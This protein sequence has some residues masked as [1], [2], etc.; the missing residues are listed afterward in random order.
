MYAT[1]ILEPSGQELVCRAIGIPAGTPLVFR[2]LRHSTLV[3][4]SES[5]TE[6]TYR[7]S[8]TDL[9]ARG[10]GDF[11]VDVQ[12]GGVDSVITTEWQYIASDKVRAE[13]DAWLSDD[14][15]HESVE[16]PWVSAT[17]HP[18]E[19]VAYLRIHD[20]DVARPPQFAGSVS[21]LKEATRSSIYELHPQETTEHAFIV[22]CGPD[23]MRKGR[24]YV[25]TSAEPVELA[26]S[27]GWAFGSG[28]AFHGSKLRRASEVAHALRPVRYPELGKAQYSSIHS[29]DFVVALWRPDG[30]VEF[31]TDYF[32]TAAWY[33]YRSDRVSIVASSLLLAATLALAC[34]E[35]LAL[36]VETVDADFTSLT[37]AFQQPLLDDME[38]AG[39]TCVRPDTVL[40]ADG[41][42]GVSRETSQLGLDLARPNDSQSSGTRSCSMM[43]S[44][45]SL[46]TA[47]QSRT[48]R[49]SVPSDATLRVVWTRALCSPHF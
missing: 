33:E 35:R 27:G 46:Q 28:C 43:R 22:T 32:G 9:A 40:V 4:E 2:L 6:P 14:V 16:L 44:L 31:H 18:Y 1:L 48:I 47:R 26:A 41:D 17:N 25:L 34:G 39:F 3:D 13:Y 19:T 30:F 21:K 37:Q 42:G 23:E 15:Q 11:H 49:R 24:T 36:N 7:W 12:I 8:V 20:D 29:G 45:K 10:G 38:L 5:T